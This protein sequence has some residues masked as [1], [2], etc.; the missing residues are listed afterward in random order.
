MDCRASFNL[1]LCQPLVPNF[2]AF[3]TLDKLIQVAPSSKEDEELESEEIWS[4]LIAPLVN[5]DSAART[6]SNAFKEAPGHCVSGF[7][8]LWSDMIWQLISTS[9]H[10]P[11]LSKQFSFM[12][13]GSRHYEREQLPHCHA[14]KA[15]TGQKDANDIR[16]E[17]M[18]APLTFDTFHVILD[19]AGV[20]PEFIDVS[21]FT[22][23]KR[24]F[25]SCRCGLR[26]G[27]MVEENPRELGGGV[28]VASLE[29]GSDAARPLGGCFWHHLTVAM[30][31]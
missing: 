28:S 27:M 14:A 26:L 31:Y 10:Q 2:A 4:D 25:D 9:M 8:T 17:L 3:D 12:F 6:Q 1:K 7:W 22:A 21:C 24:E 30:A 18:F 15:A 13:P 19:H 20:I 16:L 23:R 5:I 11:M 29:D